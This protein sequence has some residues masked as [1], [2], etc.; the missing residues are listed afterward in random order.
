MTS[1][2]P[3]ARSIP[4]QQQLD[5]PPPPSTRYEVGASKS[6]SNG[7]ATYNLAN[8]SNGVGGGS[9]GNGGARRRVINGQQSLAFFYSPLEHSTT[10]SWQQVPQEL[11]NVVLGEPNAGGSGASHYRQAIRRT[12]VSVVLSFCFGLATMVFKSP[13]SGLEFF[14]GYLVEQSLSKCR[15]INQRNILTSGVPAALNLLSYALLTT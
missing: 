7:M 11:A 8:D 4:L 12:I 5:I 10:S 15:I 1:T 13:K 14:A 3:R 6:A 2:Y 9:K